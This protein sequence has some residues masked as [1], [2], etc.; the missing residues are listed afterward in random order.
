MTITD[1]MDVRIKS[2]KHFTISAGKGCRMFKVNKGGALHLEN[3]VIADTTQYASGAGIAISAGGV[4]RAAKTTFRANKNNQHQ[5]GAFYIAQGGELRCRLCRFL[6]NHG[7]RVGGGALVYPGATAIF[8][9]TYFDNQNQASAGDFI[10]AGCFSYRPCARASGVD[11]P[12]VKTS[13]S[14]SLGSMSSDQ[15]SWGGED[16]PAPARNFINCRDWNRGNDREPEYADDKVC[17][18]GVTT[19]TVTLTSTTTTTATSTRT[20]TTTTTTTTSATGTT[21]TTL[22]QCNAGEWR[23]ASSNTCQPCPD[24][25]YQPKGSHTMSRCEEHRTKCSYGE[26]IASPATA[27]SN[28]V[29]KTSNKCA[30]DEWESKAKVSF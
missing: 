29:C 13:C 3:V 15:I 16:P 6:G 7:S 10:Y 18:L 23:A 14:A 12:A 1:G 5:G 25:T 2:E 19:T 9:D 22:R 21:V 20:T 30:D 4:V 26:F 17:A 11:M 27:T 24:G 28:I 8:A